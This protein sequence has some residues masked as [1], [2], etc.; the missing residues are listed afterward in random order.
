MA[1][2]VHP[3]TPHASYI[4]SH[5]GDGPAGKPQPGGKTGLKEGEDGMAY[6][7]VIRDP[8]GLWRLFC[9]MLDPTDV[10]LY[11]TVEAAERDVRALRSSLKRCARDFCVVPMPRAS[12][13]N[14]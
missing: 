7:I 10:I 14:V 11:D 2:Q 4:V 5:G 6:M 8:D 9:Y 13:R 1:G 12:A 3:P